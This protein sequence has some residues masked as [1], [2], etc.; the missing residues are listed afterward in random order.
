[1]K[2]LEQRNQSHEQV[3]SA[4]T[5]RQESRAKAHQGR[6]GN[7]GGRGA[8]AQ[9]AEAEAD[10]PWWTKLGKKNDRQSQAEI[11][12]AIEALT[13]D[14]LSRPKAPMPIGGGIYL[15][16]NS[17]TGVVYVGQTTNFKRRI[18]HHKS[19]LR[20]SRHTN[21]PLQ[22]DWLQYGEASFWFFPIWLLHVAEGVYLGAAEHT[23]VSALAHDRCYNTIAL[24]DR[25][26]DSAG[27]KLKSRFLRMTTSE[28]GSFD[29]LGGLE[30]LRAAIKRAKPPA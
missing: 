9:G 28:W 20:G 21:R 8:N 26:H 5:K 4:P 16:A 30:W 22:R 25:R 2:L 15:I 27:V 19:C 18:S 1:M 11:R 29:E 23:A 24:F 6:R 10:R 14:A 13:A 7:G 3:R 17:S 12:H